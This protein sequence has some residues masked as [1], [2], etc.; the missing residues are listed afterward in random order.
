MHL[1]PGSQDLFSPPGLP[2]YIKDRGNLI[3]RRGY[4]GDGRAK[5]IYRG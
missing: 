3:K 5:K 1:E 4:L 2:G